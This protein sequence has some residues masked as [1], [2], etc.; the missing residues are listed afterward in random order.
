MTQSRMAE[1]LGVKRQS[2]NTSMMRTKSMSLERF[3]KA[4]DALGYKIVVTPKDSAVGDECH[5]LTAE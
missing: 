3:C 4:V 2:I 5:V 1:L